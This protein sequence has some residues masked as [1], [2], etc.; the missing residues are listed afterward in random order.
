MLTFFIH[1]CTHN[2]TKGQSHTLFPLR[3]AR[4]AAQAKHTYPTAPYI[5]KSQDL[6]RKPEIF[7]SQLL[8]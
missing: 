7:N 5:G 2:E 6:P 4:K 3:Q 8:F 1:K